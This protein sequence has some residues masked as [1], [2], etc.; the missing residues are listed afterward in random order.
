MASHLLAAH[1]HVFLYRDY[2][3]FKS[4]AYLP[5]A[6][7][8]QKRARRVLLFIPFLGLFQGAFGAWTFT[9]YGTTGA[10]GDLLLGTLLLTTA[11]VSTVYFTF[12]SACL[13]RDTGHVEALLSDDSNLD[14]KDLDQK[15]LSGDSET[16]PVAASSSSPFGEGA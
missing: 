6:A 12:W 11:V 2:Q 4:E 1:E 16:A 8:L 7:R 3:L 10:W 9:Q 5:L 15:D 14:Q 13:Y